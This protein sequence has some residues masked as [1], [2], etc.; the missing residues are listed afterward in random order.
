VG[1]HGARVASRRG[2]EAIRVVSEQLLSV[3]EVARLTGLSRRS[4]YRAVEAG[5]LVAYRLRNRVLVSETSY[6]TWLDTNR[7]RARPQP[8]VEPVL[9]P[10]KHDSAI[11]IALLGEERMGSHVD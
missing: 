4:V 11:R 3:E 6:R 2:R 7:V 1:A 5:E 8:R 9:R 10:A